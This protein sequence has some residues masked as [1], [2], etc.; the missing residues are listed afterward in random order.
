MVEL[1]QRNL[2]EKPWGRRDVPEVFGAGA[3]Q[4]GEAWFDRADDPLPVLVKWLFTSEKL[5]V[6]VH[7]DDA[8]AQAR[9]LASGKEECWIIVDAEPG[10]QIGMGLRQAMAA[11]TVRDAA[12]S[13]AIVDLIDW[14]P[15]VAGDWYFIPPGTIHAIG[16]GIRLVEIQQN[17]DIT[18]RLYDYGRPR[19]LHLDDGIAVAMTDRFDGASGSIAERQGLVEVVRS[20]HFRIESYRGEAPVELAPDESRLFVPVS[21]CFDVDG[22]EIGSG[23]VA[24]GAANS[25]R[26]TAPDDLIL[27]ATPA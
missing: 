12:L 16:A 18:Y 3:A 10:A 8:Q 15:V 5:S 4:V 19:E 22:V 21:G 6:Q 26:G 7:P 1:L 9:G 17:A 13:G 11:D 20:A 25:L 2:V 24:R 14:K 27:L 23:Q